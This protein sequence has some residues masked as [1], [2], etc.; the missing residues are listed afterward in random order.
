M[1]NLRQQKFK[2]NRLA[3][4]NLTNAAIAAGYSRKYA[5][6]KGTK[7]DRLIRV[8]L[9]SA[10]EQAGLTDKAIVE[11]ALEGLKATKAISCNVIAQNGEGMKDANS[12]TKD[13]VDVPDWQARH[14]Y[15]E[16]ILKLTGKLKDKPLIDLSEHKT[17]NVTKIDLDERVSFLKED[18]LQ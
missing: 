3:G 11:H 16:T 1:L 15:F 2:A 6:A 13:F 8:E 18:A 14:K 12:M 10:F 4:M 17:Y 9:E 7:I 5:M